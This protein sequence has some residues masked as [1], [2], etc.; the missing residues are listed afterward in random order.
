VYIVTENQDNLT[1]QGDAVLITVNGKISKREFSICGGS[2]GLFEGKRI[3]RAKNLEKLEVDIKQLTQQ[4]EALRAKLDTQQQEFHRL[5]AATRKL[6]I[7][8]L[9]TEINLIN[10]EMVAVT[11]KKEQL[12]SM[13]SNNSMKSEEMLE[14]I[15][16]LEEDI[17]QKQPLSIEE[18]SNLEALEEK[19]VYM[20]EALQEQNEILSNKS[21]AYNQENIIFHQQQNKLSSLEQEISFKQASFDQSKERIDNNTKEA[22]RIKNEIQELLS[23]TDVNE[24]ELVELYKEK[25]LIESGLQEAE[26]SYY[27][28][29]SQTDGIDS[30]IREIRRKRDETE[31]SLSSI[32]TRLTE[33]RLGLTSLKERLAVEFDTDLDELLNQQEAEDKPLGSLEE[34]QEKVTKI[35]ASMERMGPIN[36]MA[37]EAYQEIKERGDF[38]GGQKQD[39]VNAKESLLSTISEIDNVAKDTF[40]VAFEQIRENFKNVFRSLFTEEDKCDLK[41]VDPSNPLDSEIEIMAQPKGKRP[42]TI[43][44]LSGGEKTLTA[45]SLLFSIYL[46]KPAPF[47]IFDEVD[48]PLDDVNIDKFNN[49]IRKFS[50]ESQF[51]IVTHNKRTMS[52]TDVIYG[53]T[54]IEQGVSRLVPVDLRE[55]A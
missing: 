39:L 24:D 23:R 41:L 27:G 17:T 55:L 7:D 25:E 13:L 9:Q 1:D 45:I 21:S 48:A 46:L 38:I 44:Q 22:E 8:N 19:L 42:L 29:R 36:P 26:R 10:Q 20:N 33:T 3:G 47:C 37:M 32:Q 5:K 52:S 49:I 2:V 14:R 18:R 6:E 53:I 30:E 12:A 50:G 51:I 16:K 35:K 31:E 40:F 54:M 28:L 4:I 15:A 34:L 43:N 11:S